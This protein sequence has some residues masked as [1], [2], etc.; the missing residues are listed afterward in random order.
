MRD[1]RSTTSIGTRSLLRSRAVGSAWS[2]RARAPTLIALACGAL[3]ITSQVRADR[4]VAPA[5]IESPRGLALGTG[6]RA[7]AASSQAQAEN[8]ANLVLGRVYHVESFTGYDPTFK[9]FGWG[10]SV[11]DSNTSR[12]AA[13]ISARALFGDNDAGEN[14]GWEGRLGLG[15]P[16]GDMLSIGVAGRYSNMTISDTR[17]VP[18]HPAIAATETSEAVPADRR[19]K[20][21][22]FT[23]DAALTLR[24]VPGLSISALGYN[25]ID[26]DSPLA[27][28]M[29]GGSIAFS[30]SGLTVGGDVLVDLNTHGAFE[31]PA[32]VFGGGVEF[33]LGGMAPLRA[34]YAYDQ[35]RAQHFITGG[36]GF[37]DPRFGVQLSLRQGLGSERETSLFAGLS[38][39]VQ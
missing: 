36:I 21:K 28:M 16:I 17:A 9:R 7:A 25:L 4:V 15:L 3:L 14:S 27:P 32:P 11:V 35:G 19:F 1:E 20:L 38:Y 29:V 6:A 22:A 2:S 33:L 18:E 39:F 30:S 12:L 34:G 13:G 37:V 31:G 26:T 5:R 24:L 10:G 8:P 23:L